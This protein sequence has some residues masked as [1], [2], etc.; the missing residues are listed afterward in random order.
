MNSSGHAAS[1]VDEQVA[2]LAAIRSPIE[3]AR[4]VAEIHTRLRYL[5]KPLADLRRAAVVEALDG[6]SRK[7]IWLAAQL[8][9]STSRISQIVKAAALSAASTEGTAS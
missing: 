9:L 3:R 1:A 5:P 4:R 2:A 8:G 6:N 7:R